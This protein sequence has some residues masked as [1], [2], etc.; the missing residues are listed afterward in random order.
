MRKDNLNP[1]SW[2]PSLYFIEGLPWAITMIVSTLLYKNL[3]ISNSDIALYTSWLYLPWVIKPIWSPFIDSIKTKRF[4]ILLMQFVIGCGLGLIALTIP[5]ESFFKYSLLIFWLIAFS[6]A[7]HDIAA[8]GFYMLSLSSHDQ[9]WYIGIRNTFYRIAIISA[10]GLIIITVGLIN[11]SF[12]DIKTAWLIMFIFLG[13]I[14]LLSA[15]YHL[16]KLPHSEENK[17]KISLQESLNKFYS[18][19]SSFFK[20]PAIG[21]SIIFI[22][23]YRFGEAQLVKIAPLF[24]LDPNDSGGLG[25]TN[26]EYGF[27]YGTIG[28][29]FLTIG[30]IAGGFIV[31]K[32]GLKQWIVW[33]A[34]A[35]KLPDIAYVFMAY[36]LPTSKMLIGSLICIEQFGYGFGFTAYLLYMMMISK[37]ENSTSHYA[38]CTGIMAMGMM[39][40]GMFSGSIQESIGYYYFFI[41]VMISTIPGLI[42]IKYITIDSKFGIKT[43]NG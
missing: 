36:S 24:M 34:L 21:I 10:Q 38:I 39:V 26:I 12:E 25:L 31:A 20:K 22:L 16:K 29:I 35:M 18:I 15:L 13:I 5:S 17:T 32:K 42:M 27:L 4:W 2:V 6:S 40:P 11:K 8:D 14:L 43:K 7:T 9:A 30:G 23:T 37:G 19:L 1:W 28:T 41:W 33:M 3:N